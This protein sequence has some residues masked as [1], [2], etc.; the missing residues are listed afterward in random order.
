MNNST[1]NK[2]KTR[3]KERKEKKMQSTMNNS[4]SAASGAALAPGELPLEA[5]ILIAMAGVI[6]LCI[7]GIAIML[8]LLRR[9]S[10]QRRKRD[11]EAAN[12]KGALNLYVDQPS[13]PPAGH[14]YSE[15]SLGYN[16][17]VAQRPPALPAPLMDLNSLAAHNDAMTMQQHQSHNHAL[18]KTDSNQSKTQ[19]DSV[20]H[21]PTPP[22]EPLPRPLA[23]SAPVNSAFSQP[24]LS[25]RDINPHL[26]PRRLPTMIGLQYEKLPALSPTL[27][28]PPNVIRC[29]ICS[30]LFSSQTASDL[31]RRVVHMVQ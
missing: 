12:R 5:I 8:C 29:P 18:Q 16:A 15:K 10:S 28:A 14:L 17:S 13:T 26:E 4:S 19:Y 2:K 31:H 3:K 25:P 24:Q 1:T 7:I 9:Q 20:P 21:N 23:Q 22:V 27:P 6:L 30:M 11:L